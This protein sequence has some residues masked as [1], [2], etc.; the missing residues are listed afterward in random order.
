M[1]D[2]EAIARPGKAD[3]VYAKNHEFWR[4]AFELAQTL[5]LFK[6]LPSKFDISVSVAKELPERI[7]HAVGGVVSDVSRI[8]GEAAQQAGK[9]FLTGLGKPL[10]IG[11]GV[12]LGLFLLLRRDP[13]AA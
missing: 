11:G 9:G 3:D 6:E 5:V 4:E 2:V 12:A 7:G 10:I 13:K 1:K 8:V